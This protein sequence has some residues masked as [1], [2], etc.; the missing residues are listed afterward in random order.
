MSLR[1]SHAPDLP[2]IALALGDMP[3]DLVAAMKNVDGA[4]GFG[5]AFGG[6]VGIDRGDLSAHLTSLFNARGRA[7]MTG[8]ATACTITLVAKFAFQRLS[9][10]TVSAHPFD[11][12]ALKSALTT[13]SLFSLRTAV[14]IY[15]YHTTTDD[16]VPV[17]VANT[18][19]AKSC[20][21]GDR[22]QIVRT[23]LNNHI[24]EQLVGA[25]GAI[26]FLAHRF[27]GAPV[28]NNCPN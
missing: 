19:V 28:I 17:R 21:L 27:D 18:F 4:Y 1:P 3:S 22:I 25:P 15:D 11:T 14:P 23:P 12:P 8:S 26:Q 5:L 13:N 2:V 20:A 16:I 10:Y 7:A 24:T 6:L 9:S